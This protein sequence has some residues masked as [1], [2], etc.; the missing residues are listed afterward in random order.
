MRLVSFEGKEEPGD[1]SGLSL[2]CGRAQVD[3]AI[4]EPQQNQI[5]TPSLHNGEMC[6][7]IS[8]V[9]GDAYSWCLSPQ[10]LHI[11][12]GRERPGTTT[13]GLKNHLGPLSTHPSSW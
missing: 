9:E 8:V 13:A 3:M 6:L 1:H 10:P 12:Q 7:S 11:E 2:H 5:P 4:F